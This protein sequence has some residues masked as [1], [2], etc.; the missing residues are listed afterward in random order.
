MGRALKRAEEHLALAGAGFVICATALL[1]L[2]AVVAGAPLSGFAPL[3]SASPWLLLL[4]S[5]ALA[6]AVTACAL[7]LGVP[8][9]MLLGRA[10]IPGKRAALLL[11]ALPAFLPPFLLALGWF[12]LPHPDALFSSV[13]AIGVETFAFAPIVTALVALA[14]Q[15]IDPS[16]EEAGRL[17]A[18]P[19]KVAVRIVLPVAW[20]AAA[21]G[22]LLVFALSLSELGV[23]MFLRIRAYPAA[24]FS[25]LG[26][27]D[28][29][30]GEAAVLAMPLIAVALALL[31]VERS[32]GAGRSFAVLGL[33]SEE[34]AALNLGRF[35]WTATVICWAAAVA[36]VLPIA[37]LARMALRGGFAQIGDWL[38]A[39]IGNSV[40]PA[41]L[42]A[43]LL[44]AV[45]LILGRSMARG[46]PGSGWFDALA[47]FAFVTPAAVLGVGIID[48]WNR[49][50]THAVYR[51]VAILVIGFAARYAVIPARAIAVAIA[52]GSP[53]LEEAAAVQGAG[54][55]LRLRRIV[56]PLHG[57]ALLGAWLLAFV[58]CLRDLETVILFYPPGSAPLTVRI[59]TLEANGAP[60]VVAALS[61]VQCGMVAAAIAAGAVALA[62]ARR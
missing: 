43:T 42:A 16:M 51:T 59:L 28:Y 27:I 7:L 37:G 11:H 47:V 56:V 21:L 36:S 14:V 55:F 17:S 24:V 53:H 23:P 32:I 38:G 45:G 12:Y 35:R 13:G 26:A 22:A 9:G 4:R 25:R 58:F 44:T 62:G 31:A 1:P 33:R 34:R 6:A 2:V 54:F 8:L 61:L 52:Q 46:R 29:S 5:C 20:P 15:A 49:P 40:V 19:W 41:A 57:R 60:P 30:P 48:V 18:P 3:A 50:A 39:G 10:N